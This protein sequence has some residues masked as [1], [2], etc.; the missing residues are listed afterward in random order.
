MVV[1]INSWQAWLLAIR[2]KTLIGAIMPVLIGCAVA[3]CE[4]RGTGAEFLWLPAL[5]CLSVAC[6][7]QIAAN[8]VNDLFDYLKG[9]DREDRLGPDRAFAQGWITPQS[10]KWGIVAVTLV[11]CLAGL[12]LVF[13]SGWWL[14]IV[15]ALCVLFAYLYTAGPYPL[16]YHGWGDLLVLLFFGL[17]PVGLTAYIQT[18]AWSWDIVQA[19]L[20]CGLVID[21][22]L[23]INN[24]RDRDTDRQSGKR[25]I[26]VRWGAAFGR[27]GYWLLGVAAVALYWP[28]AIADGRWELLLPSLYLIPHTIA[29]RL[30]V[31]IDHGS[32]LNRIFGRTVLDMSIYG[33]LVLWATLW[34]S[35]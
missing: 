21:T 35:L 1:E 4:L 6:F 17:V 25:T 18:G 11:A 3:T 8:L 24:F 33:V 23:M 14:V 29:W 27:W 32:E 15:G 26:V 22:M 28:S 31:R 7:L 9:A 2:P 5:L 34:E 10:M 19:G 16:A 12:P 13:Y 30:M 20:S